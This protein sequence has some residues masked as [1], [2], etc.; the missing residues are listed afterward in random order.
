M[1]VSGFG[2]VPISIP[3]T[4]KF[5]SQWDDHQK[6]SVQQALYNKHAPQFIKYNRGKIDGH[7][8]IYSNVFTKIDLMRVLELIFKSSSRGL[9]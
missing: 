8:R 9:G 6:L 3:W 2:E 5:L 4:F 7:F 1:Q